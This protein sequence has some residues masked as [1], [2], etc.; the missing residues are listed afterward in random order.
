MKHY[1][2][3]DVE[4]VGLSGEGFQV[5]VVI[6]REDGAILQEFCC[7]C[8]P[9]MAEG[10]PDGRSWVKENVPMLPHSTVHSTLDVRN[11]F[12]DFWEQMQDTYPGIMMVA[13][14]PFPVETGFLHQCLRD[15]YLRKSPYPLLDLTSMLVAR[16]YDPYMNHDRL[17]TELPKHHAL[18][19]ARQSARLL[20]G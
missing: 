17:P 5:G 15:L 19:D 2:V 16:G 9:S 8:S 13:D 6:I 14:V 3:F 7:Q 11:A 18:M 20:V 4:S 1:F 10:S 12:W